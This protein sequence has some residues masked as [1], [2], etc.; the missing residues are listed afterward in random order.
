MQ[1]YGNQICLVRNTVQGN[2]LKVHRHVR[3]KMQSARRDTIVFVESAAAMGGVQFST[4]YLAQS[5]DRARWN[6]IVVCPEEGDLTRA[7]RDAGVETQVV[8]YPKLLSTSIRVGRSARLPN[9]IAWVWDAFVM[10]RAVRSLTNFL[11]R[12]SPDVVVTKGLS[13]HF[14]GGLAAR[15]S[16]IPCVWHVQDF[17]SE[18]SFGI[19]RRVFGWAARWFPQSVIVDGGMIEKQL[20]GSLQSR[21]SVVHNGV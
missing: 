12:T 11:R 8:A 14:V 7:C 17:I 10:S 20:P 4:L 21:T 5:L 15:K 9:A 3:Y 6:P 18:R 19:Y 1:S 16:L 13:S 2:G